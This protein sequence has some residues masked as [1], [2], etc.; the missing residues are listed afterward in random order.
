[1]P[2]SRP[3][4]QLQGITL[5]QLQ[6][7]IDER[8]LPPVAKWNPERCGH[9]GMRIARDGTWYHDGRPIGRPAMVRL[10]S[11][12][13]RREADGRHV[14][15]T[16]VE[17]LEIDVEGAAFRAVEMQSEGEGEDRR[18]AFGLDSGDAVILG[19][20]H[21]LKIVQAELG[22]SPRVLIRHGL[23]AE[24]TR[25]VYYELAE[26]AITE[27]REPPGLWSDGVFFGLDI[28]G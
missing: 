11:T 23:E 19:P 16:P 21:P 18:I 13:L 2:E 25:P 26:L 14:L 3:P 4:I 5:A 1:M 24:L 15:V 22:P 27:G 10:F 28:G 8:R 12:V 17:K 6:K 9:S 20:D 7:L